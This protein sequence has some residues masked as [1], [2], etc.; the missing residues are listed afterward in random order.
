M[1]LAI[2]ASAAAVVSRSTRLL[3]AW[4]SLWW[5]PRLKM[6]PLMRMA[7]AAA[8][9]VH[10][11]RGDGHDQEHHEQDLGDA[12]GASGCALV[13]QGLHGALRV[14]TGRAQQGQ[15]GHGCRCPGR[16]GDVRDNSPPE[17]SIMQQGLALLLALAHELMALAHE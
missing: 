17:A 8:Q 2:L 14:G 6:G 5:A 3:A 7:G 10:D 9:Q 1:R 11:E 13:G 16:G 12:G 4:L 15:P